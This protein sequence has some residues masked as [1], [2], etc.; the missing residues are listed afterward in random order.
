MALQE[1]FEEQGNYLFRY[2]G[3]L[4]LI[5]LVLGIFALI[6]TQ[7]NLLNIAGKINWDCYMLYCIA[8]CFIGLGIRIFTVGHAAKNTSGRNTKGQVADEVNV[9]GIY[10]MVRH[11]LYVGNFFMWLG[12][13][14]LSMNLWFLFAFVFI[15]WVYYEKIMYAEEQFL[16]KKF[17]SAYTEWA[18]RTP[19]FV[20]KFSGYIPPQMPFDMKKILRQEKNGFFAIF[21]VTYVF[22]TVKSLVEKEGFITDGWLFYATIASGII[23]F[24]LKLLKRSALLN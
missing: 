13:A 16:R 20:P 1:E 18:A 11:P 22:A 6:D 14:M 15:Y 24:V 5:F 9:S 4:P 3:T 7:T 21:L 12:V 10:S 19:A 17:G 2:R 8:V 23:Y